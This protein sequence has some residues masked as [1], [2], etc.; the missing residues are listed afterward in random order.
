MLWRKNKL[1]IE[2]FQAHVTYYFEYYK[3]NPTLNDMQLS[4]VNPYYKWNW[5][6]ILRSMGVN[7]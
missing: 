4:K 3:A 7:F 5:E 6:L 1:D 2:K